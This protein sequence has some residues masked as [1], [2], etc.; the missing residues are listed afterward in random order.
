M[1]KNA[2]GLYAVIKILWKIDWEK[3]VYITV[4]LLW[5]NLYSFTVLKLI[6]N[7]YSNSTILIICLQ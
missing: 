3:I 2:S 6:K 4:I 7:D 1:H 5:S